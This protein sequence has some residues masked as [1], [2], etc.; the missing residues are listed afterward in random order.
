LAFHH[1]RR[2]GDGAAFPMTAQLPARGSTPHSKI[3]NEFVGHLT[4]EVAV[5]QAQ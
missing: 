3:M 5:E 2:A 4:R 1:R